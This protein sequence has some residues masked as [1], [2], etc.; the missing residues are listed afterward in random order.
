MGRA[1]SSVVTT[2]KPRRGA[3]EREG[4][5]ARSF[6]RERRKWHAPRASTHDAHSIPSDVR[7]DQSK[8]C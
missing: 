6:S 2:D 1:M 3:D 7:G 5:E 8:V 4:W